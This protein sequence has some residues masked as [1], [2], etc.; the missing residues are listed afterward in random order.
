MIASLKRMI[1]TVQGEIDRHY[2]YCYGAG[3]Q[4]REAKGLVVYV[5]QGE[6]F[7]DYLQEQYGTNIRA[8]IQGDV[9]LQRVN[10]LGKTWVE[11]FGYP[12]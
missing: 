11:K 9:Q 2:Y 8:P 6:R 12:F 1:P 3:A 4:E 5:V 7:G 10:I